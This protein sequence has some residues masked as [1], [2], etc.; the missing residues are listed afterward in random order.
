MKQTMSQWYSKQANQ[1][2]TDGSMKSQWKVAYHRARTEA[3]LYQHAYLPSVQQR[4]DID[5]CINIEWKNK[6]P[7][8][9]YVQEIAKSVAGSWLMTGSQDHLAKRPAGTVL[10]ALESS[11][12][13][14]PFAEAH[15]LF[16]TAQT[17][18]DLLRSTWGK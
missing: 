10:A 4:M 5:A 1:A 9:H 17:A 16:G 7:V 6:A 2:V 12:M 14:D 18:A 11:R 15:A 13:E 3:T 8:N